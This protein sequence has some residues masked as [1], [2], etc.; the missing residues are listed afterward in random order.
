M[1]AN[2]HTTLRN[3]LTEDKEGIARYYYRIKVIGGME[4][5]PLK[6]IRSDGNANKAR[7]RPTFEVLEKAYSNLSK[8]L[9]QN[10]CIKTISEDAVYNSISQRT[11][12]KFY[13]SIW[14]GNRNIDLFCPAVGQLYLP[15]I[16]GHKI[17]RHQIMR[18]L[19][20]EIDGAIHNRELKM[21]KD[22][23][24]AHILGELGI[25]YTVVP[26]EDT[27][28]P[29]VLNMIADLKKMTRLDSRARKRLMR[30]VY[31]TT[32]LY[33]ASDEVIANL[34]QINEKGAE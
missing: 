8:E 29:S 34:Y 19:A 2:K 23:H 6:G 5:L 22:N 18:G 21:K 9:I 15:N 20:I 1:K 31:V 25:G 32:L 30:K 10:C 3:E 12:L 4:K 14:I 17:K 24:K 33:H 7:I 27:C 16:K 11:N 28:H 26:N 13:R